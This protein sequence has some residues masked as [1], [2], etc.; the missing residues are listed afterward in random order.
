MIVF[1]FPYLGEYL[2]DGTVIFRPYVHI[3]LQ[4]VDGR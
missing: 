4:G 1:T 2:E 3:H